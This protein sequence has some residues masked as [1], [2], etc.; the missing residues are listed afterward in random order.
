ML[1]L[2][3]KEKYR[4]TQSAITFAVSQVRETMNYVVDDVRDVALTQI[5]QLGVLSEEQ[6][7]SLERVIEYADPFA[8]LQSEYMQT[9]YYREN[10]NLVVRIYYVA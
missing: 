5:C 4:L 7:T 3:L 10:F 8:G 2:T 6:Q 1:L 9:K